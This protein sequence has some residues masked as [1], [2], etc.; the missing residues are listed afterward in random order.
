MNY[1]YLEPRWLGYEE[2]KGYNE[3]DYYEVSQKLDDAGD[4]FEEITDFLYGKKE[5]N[6]VD[7]ESALNELGA[8]L[9]RK[10]PNKEMTVE[11][12]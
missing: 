6:V 4:W 8:Y 7:F 11:I 3:S 12:Y 1:D 2:S 5:F 10:L 9:N